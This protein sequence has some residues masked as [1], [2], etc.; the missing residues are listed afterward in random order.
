MDSITQA[1]YQGAADYESL[2]A[3]A[4]YQY[5][6]EEEAYYQGAADYEAAM[7]AVQSQGTDASTLEQ[8]YYLGAADYE[9]ALSRVLYG[10]SPGEQDAYYQGALAAQTLLSGY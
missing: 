8:A 9:D 4:S 5:T 2:L 3:Q 7:L 1:Y 6:P 10:S